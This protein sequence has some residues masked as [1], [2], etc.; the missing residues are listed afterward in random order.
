MR[1]KYREF[2]EYHTSLDNLELVTPAGLEGSFVLH[3]DCIDLLERNRVYK[4]TCL[5]EPQLGKRGLYPTIATK[6]SH[7][8]VT[9]ML[10]FIA[11]ADGTNDLI[12]ISNTIRVPARNLYPIVDRLIAEGLLQEQ[13]TD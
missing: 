13:A 4:V 8:L 9:D 3:K 1:T 6:N 7:R 10:N 11:Y 2:P 12:D 5:G